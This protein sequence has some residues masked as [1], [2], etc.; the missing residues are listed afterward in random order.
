[1]RLEIVF[2]RQSREIYANGTGVHS[3]SHSVVNT[4]LK[5]RGYVNDGD[6][7]EGEE[8]YL[9]G[10]CMVLVEGEYNDNYEVRFKINN[11]YMFGRIVDSKYEHLWNLLKV[12]D[13]QFVMKEECCQENR[14]RMNHE[15]F[16]GIVKPCL[17]EIY[18]YVL[19]KECVIYNLTQY[20]EKKC[21]FPNV[22]TI[23]V[24][25][26][27]TYCIAKINNK[28]FVELDRENKYEELEDLQ[29]CYIKPSCYGYTI[30]TNKCNRNCES[31]EYYEEFAYD[32]M[33]ECIMQSIH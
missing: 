5:F 24:I 16:D 3:I 31:G 25:E 14:P 18:E 30:I 22:I 21:Y 9:F 4:W 10:S 11:V 32:S 19:D 12:E 27:E 6:M 7:N 13:A 33:E 8:E 2:D 15:Q 23:E 29:A 17:Q 26:T 20:F 28:L 1:M